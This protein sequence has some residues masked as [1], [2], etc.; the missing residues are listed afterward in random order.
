MAYSNQKLKYIRQKLGLT[1][2]EASQKLG[3]PQNNLSIYELGKKSMKLEFLILLQETFNI[4]IDKL[5]D[6]SLPYDDYKLN[7]NNSDKSKNTSKTDKTIFYDDLYNAKKTHK[8]KIT[9]AAQ[10][11]NIPKSKQAIAK[12]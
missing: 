4:S 5:I 7:D 10:P 9:E 1:Q 11:I 12:L 6:V 3:I 8:L 2:K